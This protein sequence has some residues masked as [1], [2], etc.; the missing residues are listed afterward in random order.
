MQFKDLLFV[1]CSLAILGLL[2][3]SVY[4]EETPE[5]AKYQRQ[6]YQLQAK[7][8]GDPK[9]ASLPL[10]IKQ[11]WN[12]E[13]GRA[14][15]CTTCHMG[16]DKPSFADAPQPLKT[17]P[18]L[19]GYMKKHPFDKFGCT[20]CHDGDGRAT[21]FERTHRVVEHLERQP[22][23][24]PYAQASCARCHLELHA[25]GVEF[26][27]TPELNL[28]KRLVLELG[29]G[30]CHTIRQMGTSSSVAPE[31]SGF[32]SQTELAFKLLHDFTYRNLKGEHSMRNW[33]FEH[34]KDPQKIM[35]G[36]TAQNIP[37]T[38]MPNYGLTDEEARSLTVF[39]M[40]L[41]DRKAERIPF[42]Y[43]PKLKDHDEFVQY[44]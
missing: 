19:G 22:L 36:N 4:Q 42:N 21:R 15:R 30:G 6:F 29:C 24:G 10:E 16:I 18:D 43:M 38:S 14:D 44:R 5:W 40:S 41:K 33:E 28:G 23:S 34:F 2:G 17:H 9:M 35:P 1:L 11:T 31:L 20:I 13:L 27:E 37:T 7:N 8:L 39:V 25:A 26:S 32:G 12:Q 3:F